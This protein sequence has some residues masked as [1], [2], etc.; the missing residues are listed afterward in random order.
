LK[1]TDIQEAKQLLEKMQKYMS[2]G[3]PSIDALTGGLIRGGVTLLGGRPA[4]GRI[5]LA[6]NIVS[7]VAA[8][9]EGNILVFSAKMP[10]KEMAM[11]LLS[12]GMG[13][14]PERLFDGSVAKETLVSRYLRF[15]ES[16][17]SNIKVYHLSNLSLETITHSCQ[18]TENVNLVVVDG[19]EGI[20]ESVDYSAETINWDVPYEPI[21]KVMNALKELARE[22]NVPVIGTVNIHRSIERRQNKR[23]KLKDLK[24]INVS[25]DMADQIMFLYRDEYYHCEYNSDN[26]PKAELIVAKNSGGKT[27]LVELDF[28]YRTRRFDEATA[29]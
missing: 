16:R 4:M 8:R 24:K 21:D 22:K 20:Q 2:T 27:G 5:S 14:E 13:T 17:K 9:C 7:R 3:Y 15:Q 6:L 1:V 29:L 19:M 10:E 25:E 18:R 11:R 28:D 12:I 23:P 26:Y